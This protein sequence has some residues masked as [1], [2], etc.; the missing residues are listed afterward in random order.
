ME[1]SRH[2][3]VQVERTP[4][5]EVAT[6]GPQTPLELAASVAAAAP[7][8]HHQSSSSAPNQDSPGV[9]FLSICSFIDP[10]CVATCCPCWMQNPLCLLRVATA[11]KLSCPW[12]ARLWEGVG[13]HRQGR[14]DSITRIMVVII[15]IVIMTVVIL[16][17]LGLL[18]ALVE[19][20][21]LLFCPAFILADCA[22]TGGKIQRLMGQ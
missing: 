17:V 11:C 21:M 16:V 13:G 3:H 22:T 15:L 19:S 20:S 5:L 18:G 9:A 1:S 10:S 14:A 12:L 4:A 7:G 6:T 2:A 8:H